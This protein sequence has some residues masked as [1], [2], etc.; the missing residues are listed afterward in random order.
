MKFMS[1]QQTK[2]FVK[3]IAIV[4]FATAT[5]FTGNAWSQNSDGAEPFIVN[6]EDPG[7]PFQDD[8]PMPP[9][10]L[11]AVPMNPDVQSYS[12]PAP[13]EPIVAEMPPGA[14]VQGGGYNAAHNS[15]VPHGH[16]DHCPTCYA[17][18]VANGMVPYHQ[19]DFVPHTAS[20]NFSPNGPN[21]FGAP[22]G[23]TF[24]NPMQ[25]QGGLGLFNRP[26]GLF[27]R[28]NQGPAGGMM[29]ATNGVQGI[30][31]NWQFF[32]EYLF[33]RPRHVELTYAMPMDGPSNSF[34]PPVAAGR[35]GVINMEYDSG[36]KL[37]AN[38]FLDATS[39]LGFEYTFYETAASDAI[40]VDNPLAI[41]P[42][43]IHPSTVNAATDALAASGSA[44]I[45]LQMIDLNFRGLVSRT[46]ANSMAVLAGLRYAK[47]E[48]NFVGNF[49]GTGR[50]MVGA[51]IDF[52]G[53][54]ARLGLEY[55][56]RIPQTGVFFYGN[57]IGNLLV[58]QFDAAYAQSDQ[59]ATRVVQ[60]SWSADRLVPVLEMEMGLG[61]A[62]PQGRC[63]ISGGY[64][65][66][67]WFNTVQ[68]DEYIYAVQQNNF[69][70]LHDTL[71]F[72]G[73]TARIDFRF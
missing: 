20:R 30:L 48:Q 16:P 47:L 23:G 3:R 39:A 7:T 70:D 26:G 54:G 65:F 41:R 10:S 58:G 45:D 32:G 55:D 49:Q 2:I 69:L 68:A 21:G 22:F 29:S 62:S 27:G 44:S 67:S 38:R 18:A 56:R 53:I 37:G 9:A 64:L 5:L 71:T 52:D 50:T 31:S 24:G 17:N 57:A 11:G 72:D 43:V 4:V 15:A 73:F 19:G 63:K 46:D 59:A 42:L 1:K 12:L 36:F 25:G 61:W 14:Y 40:S 60:N 13:N 6:E 8:Q 34:F 66:Q 51:D 35:S 33:L 28:N